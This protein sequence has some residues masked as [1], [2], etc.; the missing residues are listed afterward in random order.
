VLD[1]E[2]LSGREGGK[3]AAGIKLPFGRYINYPEENA[4]HTRAGTRDGNSFRNGLIKALSSGTAA[5]ALLFCSSLT[6]Y[7]DDSL[8]CYKGDRD[9]RIYIGEISGANFQNAAEECNSFYSDCNGQCYGCYIEEDSSKEM[10][11]DSQG[12]KFIR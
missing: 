3:K 11:V 12:K 4:M 9:N 6:G 1:G 2:Q 8:S 7:A 10:C 5:V